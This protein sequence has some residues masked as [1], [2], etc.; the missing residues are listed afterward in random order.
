MRRLLFRGFRR[1]HRTSRWLRRR[2]TATGSLVLG[3]LI[4][5]AVLGVD[6]RTTLAYQ[7][8]TLAGGLLLVGLIGQRG[9]RP[10]LEARR[11]L[12]ALATVGERIR[13]RVRVHNHGP[14]VEKGLR[15]RERL[16]PGLPGYEEF[17]HAREPGEEQRNRFDRYVGY[18]RWEWLVAQRQGADVRDH[19]LPPLPPGGYADLTLELVPRRRGHVRLCGLSVLRPD[20]LGLMNAVHELDLPETLVVLPRRVDVPE[21]VLP[22]RRNYQPGGDVH[23]ASV[24]D[25]EEFMSLRDYRPG[26][27]MRRVHWRSWAKTGR[28]VVKEFQEEYLVRHALVLDTFA[29]PGQDAAFEDAVSI[30]ASLI[31]RMPRRDALLDMMFLGTRSHW[32]TSDRGRT[33]DVHMLEMLASISPTRSG[34][35]SALRAAIAPRAPLLSGC[36]CVLL[37]WD[38]ERRALVGWLRALGVAVEV[39]TVTDGPIRPE[40]GPLSDAPE[41][42]HPVRTGRLGEASAW[43]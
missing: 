34:G 19:E 2:L 8:A 30:A 18:P 12:P 16:D 35:V 32:I 26:D 20:P 39:F 9:F 13:Y 36:I 17:L 15:L 43:A 11:S 7:V 3:V 33:G 21:P 23:A 41:R 27:P 1:V 4:G 24:G 28:P 40:P 6:T 5:A 25:S 38:E 29:A 37:G 14:R 10:R 22:G 31:T 42:Y